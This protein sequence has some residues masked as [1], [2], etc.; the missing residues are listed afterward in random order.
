MPSTAGLPIVVD[1]PPLSTSPSWCL[2]VALRSV[3]TTGGQRVDVVGQERRHEESDQG[4]DSEG[5]RLPLKAGLAL[6]A[7]HDVRNSVRAARRHLACLGRHRD[8]VPSG[9]RRHR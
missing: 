1:D 5:Q 4:L 2:A 8:Q 3:V 7:K 9:L 6:A